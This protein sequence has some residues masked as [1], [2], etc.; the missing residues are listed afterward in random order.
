MTEVSIHLDVLAQT[1]IRERSWAPG[2]DATIAVMSDVEAVL[3]IQD[4]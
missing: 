2:P 4:C 3:W 1:S